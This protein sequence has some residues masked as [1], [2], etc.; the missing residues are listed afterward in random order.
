MCKDDRI[1]LAA[2]EVGLATVFRA[3]LSSSLEETAIDQNARVVRDDVISRSRYVACCSMKINSHRSS[4]NGTSPYG[5]RHSFISGRSV[6][7]SCAYW[8]HSI[9]MFLNFSFAW[10]PVDCSF[11]TR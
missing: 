7:N 3:L 2:L 1:D 10:P 9:C 11:G 8:R 5:Q 6:P 4:L